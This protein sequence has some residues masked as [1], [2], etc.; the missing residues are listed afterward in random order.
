L[1]QSEDKSTWWENPE[2]FQVGQLYPRTHFIPFKNKQQAC[3]NR[4]DQSPYYIS[5]NGKWKFRYSDNPT[6][7]PKYFYTKDYDT[8]EWDSIQV[9]ANWELQGYG[10]PIY[11]NDRYPFKKNPPF[12][13]HDDNPVGSYSRQ[14][15]IPPEWN[16]R[17]VF[18]EFGAVR[19]A[20][21]Y[22]LN[23]KFLGY[24]QGSKTPV[25]FDITD[26]V[27]E[28]EN[29]ICVEVYRYS[30]GSYLEC[31]DFWRVSG[32]ERDVFIWSTP[33]VR[34]S[35]F[36]IKTLFNNNNNNNSNDYSNADVHIEISIDSDELID[37]AICDIE[38]I[39]IDEHNNECLSHTEQ[40]KLKN[41]ETVDCEFKIP[42]TNPTLWTAETPILY[43]AIFQLKIDGNIIETVG[44]KIGFREIKIEDGLLKINGQAITLKG[45]NRHEHD[46]VNGR[47]IT[48]QSMIEDIRLMKQ[49]NINAVR[50]SH[51]PNHR[52][53]YE[54]CDQYGLY[55]VDEANIE[56][57][58]MGACFQAEF[59]EEK[60]TSALPPY[61]AAHIDRVKRMIERSK[62]H[63]C[64]IIWS[65][66][67][68][69]GN[70]ENMKAAYQWAKERD[71]SRPV[72]YEQA[73]EDWNTDIV[74]P[75]YPKIEDIIKYGLTC[76]DRPLIMCEYAHAMGNSVGNLKEY[77]DVINTFK[78]LQ[79]G[80]IWDWVDQGI[81]AYE[82]EN[83]ESGKYWKFGGDFGG[84]QIPSDGNF[85]ING[86][87]F[88]DRT[89]H[90][91]LYEVKYVYQP[92]EIEVI[93]INTGQFIIYNNYDFIPTNHID[94]Y[95]E[96]IENGKIIIANKIEQLN[97]EAQENTK[98]TIQY[99]FEKDSAKEYLINFYCRSNKDLELIPTGNEFAKQQFILQEGEFKI[100]NKL[101]IGTLSIYDKEN[102]LQI[103]GKTFSVEFSRNTGLVSSYKLQ[104]LE[105]LSE[106]PKP[107]FWRAPI[108]NDL[109]NDMP[110][111]LNAWKKASLTQTLI[112]L[113][114]RK[115]NEEITVITKYNLADLDLE[116]DLL[117]TI[118]GFGK[119]EVTGSLDTK[120]LSLPE[121]PRFGFT[122]KLPDSFDQLSWYGRGPHENYIDRNRSAFIS[123]YK[124]TVAEQYHS[125]IRP[126][127]NGN[128]T[129]TKW[130]S[131]Q[132]KDGI[133]W[134]FQGRPTFDFST[135]HYSIEELD[136]GEKLKHSNE[137]IKNNLVNVS[138]DLKQ[139]GVGGD[140][141]WGAHTHD[142]YKLLDK[143]YSFSFGLT[144]IN[145]IK[146]YT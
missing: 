13:P 79:G 12:V 19:S 105:L 135:L 62:N 141:S 48:E 115:N 40:L 41:G 75:M 2:I 143:K 140:D 16:G 146:K 126:Q 64:I 67:N 80:F 100:F 84:E 86:L 37:D 101:S 122:L 38:L 8:S 125:Y 42:F 139:M 14:F 123:Q 95:W 3:E 81:V 25:Q 57:H 85:C 61:K 106:G 99:N 87:V 58:G 35:D 22:W 102:K 43:Q 109:G 54:L 26:F 65:I 124:S 142:Q 88:P 117:Y 120:N 44:H 113:E 132:N 33:M 55:V 108:D 107:N 63:P 11:V 68:E 10:V 60:H 45:V 34:I 76:F 50:C 94:F 137:I 69:A 116:Y 1:K 91:A 96:I 93:D 36:S 59:D 130:M 136:L 97:I 104:D 118:N 23:G 29:T 17:K 103:L 30:D 6:L 128:K 56:A 89:P 51:Y 28:E 73:G 92:I 74:C 18:I 133:G 20:S 127:E 144:P 77:W 49:N 9:P 66:G 111:R 71:P 31:Q 121:L 39:L 90:P 4:W 32:I 82:N 70:G 72:Q 46:E 27:T 52:R 134:N 145:N 5:L 47:I 110:T 78:N 129:E 83:S 112:S 53:W 131:L 21:F 98:I 24:N 114:Y 119:I 138:I 15:T 7:R